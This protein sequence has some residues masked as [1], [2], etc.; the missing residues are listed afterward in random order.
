MKTASDPFKEWWGTG[1]QPT[2]EMSN[3]DNYPVHIETPKGKITSEGTVR[4]IRTIIEYVEGW[5]NGRGAKGIDSMEDKDGKRPSLM[6]DLATARISVGQV[7]QRI[8]H[9]VSCQTTGVIHTPQVV[10][11]MVDNAT[12]NILEIRKSQLKESDFI[13]T[14]NRYQIARKV[15]LKW[16]ENYTELN[17]RSLGSYTQED[18]KRIGLEVDAL[19]KE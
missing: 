14:E 8:L 16:I 6:E 19:Q 18:L 7:A 10:K 12:A 5:L 2:T 1:W 3:P 9:R 11:E 4:N 13:D 15:C 17:F